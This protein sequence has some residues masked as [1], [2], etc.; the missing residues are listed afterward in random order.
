MQSKLTV[1][2]NKG[3]YPITIVRGALSCVGELLNL[4]NRVKELEENNRR[5][6]D[7][8]FGTKLF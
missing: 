3:S 4:S 1:K 7:A 2:T 6:Q 8:V 5:L